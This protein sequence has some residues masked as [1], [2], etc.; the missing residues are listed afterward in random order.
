MD[1]QEAIMQLLQA[2]SQARVEANTG[3]FE[4]CLHPAYIYI[5]SFGQVSSKPQFIER[6]ASGELPFLAQ[7]HQQVQIQL[8]GSIALVNALLY[9]RFIW[10]QQIVSPIYRV[11]HILIQE[12]GQW[13]FVSGQTTEV[14]QR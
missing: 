9:D 7:E 6:I 12:D 11:L 3:F 2:R 13:L 8:V 4:R 14:S 5:N 1:A 10:Q